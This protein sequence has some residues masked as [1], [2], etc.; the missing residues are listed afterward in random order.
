MDYRQAYVIPG[1]MFVGLG[2]GMF[3]DQAGAGVIL[4]LGLGFILSPI[5]GMIE[6]RS[7]S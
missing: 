2:I 7:N 5:L 3:F 6:K 4:G 1:G